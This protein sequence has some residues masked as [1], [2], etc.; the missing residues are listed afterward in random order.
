MIPPIVVQIVGAPVACTEGV[1]DSWREITAWVANQLDARFGDA[2]RVEYYDLFD[3]A[4]PAL[5]PDVQ[6]PLVLVNG[7]ILS[8]GNKISIPAIR[9]CLESLG[10]LQI[11]RSQPHSNE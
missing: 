3:P 5:P 7:D 4:C 10:L 2:V 9:K 8:S 1:K 6:L 11:H